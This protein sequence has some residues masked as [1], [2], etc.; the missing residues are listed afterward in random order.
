[1]NDVVSRSARI[2]MMRPASRVELFLPTQVKLLVNVGDELAGG[3]SVVAK[4]A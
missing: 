1:L 2:S 4:F 3:Q